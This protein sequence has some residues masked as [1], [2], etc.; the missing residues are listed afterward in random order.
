MEQ[1]TIAITGA[2]GAV[3]GRVAKRLADRGVPLR[4]VVRDAARAPKLNNAEVVVAAYDDREATVRALRGVETVFFVSAFESAERVAHHKIAVDAFVEAGIKRVV[5]TSFLNAAPDSTF[6]LARDHF[7]TEQYMKAAGLSFV[8]LR[9]SLYMDILPYFES[10]GVIQGPAGAG[11]LAPVS[12]DDVADVAVAALLRDDHQTIAYD[13]TGPELM[14]MSDVARHLSQAHGKPVRFV[15]ETLEEAY[16]S[17]AHLNAPKFEL[18]GWVTSYRAI[19]VGELDVVSDTVER[20][21]GHPP[22][23]LQSFLKAQS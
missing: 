14:T 8:A 3:G 15:D 21:A 4:L 13:V 6:T 7:Q 11:K 12:R 16:A 23:S 22:M 5:Y 20:V 10:D 19:G 9:N 18:D 17:R 1:S 2:S